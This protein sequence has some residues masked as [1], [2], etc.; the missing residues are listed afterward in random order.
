M[1]MPVVVE[2]PAIAA[3]R[4]ALGGREPRLFRLILHDH[5]GW[6]GVAGDRGGA[7]RSGRARAQVV[8]SHPA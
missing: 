1:I 8:P 3:G 7:R 2:L 5:A 6:G 4:G